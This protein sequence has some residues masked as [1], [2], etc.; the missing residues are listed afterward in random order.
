MW[1]LGTM[2]PRLLLKLLCFSCK[3]PAHLVPQKI[4]PDSPPYHLCLCFQ[5]SSQPNPPRQGW[6][7]SSRLTSNLCFNLHSASS[8]LAPIYLIIRLSFWTLKVHKNIKSRNHT[9]TKQGLQWLGE[10]YELKLLKKQKLETLLEGLPP[11]ARV[12]AQSVSCVQLFMT[13]GTSLPGSSV[14]GVSQTR[15]LKW[16]AIYSS[17]G[18]SWPRDQ[19]MSPVSSVLAGRFFTTESPGKPFWA[20]SK[21]CWKPA[22][23]YLMHN[24]SGGTFH[25]VWGPQSSFQTSE[26]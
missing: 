4:S 18:S 10:R 17:R 24:L 11:C 15:I 9:D 8:F 23:K 26:F 7:P 2:S 1:D 16:V 6:N 14:H 19:T 21:M 22:G 20:A 13:P 5:T 12:H 25:E 3:H